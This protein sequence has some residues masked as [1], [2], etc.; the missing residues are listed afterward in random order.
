MGLRADNH[1]MVEDASLELIKT[2]KEKW[3][4]KDPIEMMGYYYELHKGLKGKNSIELY[5]C[6]EIIITMEATLPKVTTHE[7]ILLIEKMMDK[8]SKNLISNPLGSGE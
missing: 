3:P 7:L 5:V 6:I 4:S 1:F 2:F 8:R